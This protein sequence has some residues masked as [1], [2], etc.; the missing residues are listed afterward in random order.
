MPRFSKLAIAGLILTIVSILHSSIYAALGLFE[1]VLSQ[2]NSVGLGGLLVSSVLVWIQAWPALGTV[3]LAA[4]NVAPDE[5][6]SMIRT[7]ERR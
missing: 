1:P 6:E 7:L 5:I 4:G 3:V 2:T